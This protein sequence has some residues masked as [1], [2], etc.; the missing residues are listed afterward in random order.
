MHARL[1]MHDYTGSIMNIMHMST[2]MF[3]NMAH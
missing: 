2:G 3:C 1:I